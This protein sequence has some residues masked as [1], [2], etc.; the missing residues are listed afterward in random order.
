MKEEQLSKTGYGLQR[1]AIVAQAANRAAVAT[2]NDPRPQVHVVYGKDFGVP[3]SEVTLKF[4][5]RAMNRADSS[6]PSRPV[7]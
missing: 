7:E 2:P 5:R 6:R 3:N 4:K 1:A